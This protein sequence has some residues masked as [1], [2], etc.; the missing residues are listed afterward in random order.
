MRRPAPPTPKA[1][2]DAVRRPLPL[3]GDGWSDA[4][5]GETTGDGAPGGGSAGARGAPIIGAGPGP[6]GGDA[7][8]TAPEGRNTRA[9]LSFAPSFSITACTLLDIP[10]AVA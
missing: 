8:A 2:K 6:G 3:G 7:A 10:S 9:T 4:G 1:T 5:G